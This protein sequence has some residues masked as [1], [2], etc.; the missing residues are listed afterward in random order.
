MAENR[1]AFRR[2]DRSHRGINPGAGA[3][4]LRGVAAAR[5]GDFGPVARTIEEAA[6]LE[7]EGRT[8]TIR[9]TEASGLIID[10]SVQQGAL[11]SY[12]TLQVLQ[13]LLHAFGLV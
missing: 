6:A 7:L 10:W 2:R 4:R 1:T 13:V 12:L 8:W 5:V 3:A 9:S 11:W